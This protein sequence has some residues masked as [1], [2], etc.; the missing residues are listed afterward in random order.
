MIANYCIPYHEAHNFV[1]LMSRYRAKKPGNQLSELD[2]LR[3]LKHN[4]YE[5][6]GCYDGA[7]PVGYILLATDPDIDEAAIV[8]QF[9]C[10]PGNYGKTLFKYACKWAKKQGYETVTG[11][12]ERDPAA[13]NRLYGTE[14]LNYKIYKEL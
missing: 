7:Q 10:E 5:L 13:F 9:Y 8:L 12:V 14:I 3:G 11:I 4:A 1:A 2:V 6:I